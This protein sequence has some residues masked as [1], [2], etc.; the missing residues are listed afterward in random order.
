MTCNILLKFFPIIESKVIKRYYSFNK[1]ESFFN[2]INITIYQCTPYWC[3][4][5]I[6]LSFEKLSF[7]IFNFW[8]IFILSSSWTYCEL[9]HSIFADWYFIHKR[10]YRIILSLKYI[11]S[12]KRNISKLSN[13]WDTF[14]LLR[15]SMG[16]L[17]T[18]GRISIFFM[19]CK[20]FKKKSM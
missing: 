17:I 11:P 19:I 14:L 10:K 16:V 13:C 7:I 6:K 8:V 18:N 9:R 12:L 2:L 15:L 4:I 3:G 5:K 20:K 1:Y